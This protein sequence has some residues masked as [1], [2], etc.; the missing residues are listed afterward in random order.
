M[1]RTGISAELRSRRSASSG[2]KKNMY[3]SPCIFGRPGCAAGYSEGSAAWPCCQRGRKGAEVYQVRAAVDVNTPLAV[4]PQTRFVRPVAQD[5][6]TTVAI[7][8][9]R[10]MSRQRQL[11]HLYSSG[12]RSWAQDSPGSE[13]GCVAR[14]TGPGQLVERAARR[15]YNISSLMME[16]IG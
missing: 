1:S 15:I 13:G 16:A 3:Y 11:P 9:L 7:P 5:G 8:A 10:S 4:L 12:V 2:D 14:K 6:M